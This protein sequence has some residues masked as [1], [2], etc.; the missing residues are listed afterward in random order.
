[1][2]EKRTACPG[3]LPVDATSTSLAAVPTG[4]VRYQK[5][6]IVTF[7]TLLLDE[8]TLVM[9][10]AQRTPIAWRPSV[11]TAVQLCD[12]RTTSCKGAPASQVGNYKS[13]HQDVCVKPTVKLKEAPAKAAD[14][15]KRRA[16]GCTWAHSAS[17]VSSEHAAVQQIPPDYLCMRTYN[18]AQ[19]AR[20]QLLAHHGSS[21]RFKQQAGWPPWS[22]VHSYTPMTS[23]ITLKGVHLEGVLETAAFCAMNAFRSIVRV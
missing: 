4:C 8:T 12:S 7:N 17:L 22:R 18:Q 2:L 3:T 14:K 23:W 19:I 21:R 20:A 16:D 10:S 6:N 11:H 5:L 1:M 9:A 13:D 15:R